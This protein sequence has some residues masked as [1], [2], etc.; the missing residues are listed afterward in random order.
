[1][2]HTTFLFGSALSIALLGS[3][4]LAAQTLNV[5][6]SADIRSS[7]PAV[8]R[9]ALSDMVAMSVA[10]GLVAF[11][12]GGSIKPM[13]AEEWEVSD[14]R[15]TYT[16]TLRDGITFHNGEPL[17]AEIVKS[18]W[19]TLMA[20]PDFNC[21]SY[22]DGTNGGAVESIEVKAPDTVAI[23]LSEPDEMFLTYAAQS[24][25][26]GMAILH[27]ESWSEDGSWDHPIGTGPFVF[28]NWVRGERL[29][30]T[31]FEDYQ[32]VGT[33]ID[34]YAGLKDVLVD[35]VNLIVTPDNATAVAALRSGDLDILPYLPPGEAAELSN[36]P[37]FKVV[38]G[39]HGGMIT[40]LMQTNDPVLDS[41]EMRRAVAL[42][43]DI[44]AIVDSA[45]YGLGIPNAS[46]V[47]TGSV[48]HTDVHEERLPYAPEEVPGLLEKAGY[49]DEE[50]VIQTNRRNTINY[51]VA[52]ITQ[53]MLQAAG[54]NARIEVLEWATQLDRFRSGNF[55]L[56]AF[57]Y[58]NRPDPAL[59]YS[60]VTASKEERGSAI[61]DDP[62][63][64][65]MLDTLLQTSDQA[66]RQEIFDDLHELFLEDV[67]FLML[68]NG[69]DVG[70]SAAKVTD[71]H[72]WNGFARL[73]GVGVE[74]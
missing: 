52:V 8:N 13:L 53:A 63:A 41:P 37:D 35:D 20:A 30:L 6:L 68:A 57:N 17:T 69:L 66:E 73:W 71:Y 67:P 58:S 70:V 25:C 55:Q 36:D 7:Q 28:D 61:W 4:S 23:T 40:L 74:D 46:L 56:S 42:A 45:T 22:F 10:E 33:E 26:G 49:N 31:K 19:E 62:Q 9:D 18:S 47:A 11:G 21:S 51:D 54:I 15:R 27:P 1:M 39:P 3:S 14:D 32:S 60:A 59:A 2:R 44:P 29:H 65:E 34:G 50:L 16:F 64:I 5:Q 43:L 24:Q 38:A 12:E 72:T 48:Y